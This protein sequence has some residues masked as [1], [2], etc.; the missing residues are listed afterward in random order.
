[1]NSVPRITVEAPVLS[2]GSGPSD[3]E[4][5]ARYVRALRR[6]K[7][8]HLTLLHLGVLEDFAR[9]ICEWTKGMTSVAAATG[10]T[11]AWLDGLPV[12]DAFSGTADRL[13]PLGGGR[14]SGL[15]VGV[16]EQ[17]HEYQV[18]LVQAL[19]E[20]LDGLLVDNVDD[21]I[22]SSRALGYRSPH[23]T[24]HVAVGS[25]TAYGSG[26]WDIERL[27]IQFGPSR[28]RNRQSLL[29]GMPPGTPES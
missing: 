15:E 28:I 21:F 26:S 27:P 1:M 13:I 18:R 5:L 6:Q 12:L 3:Y 4:G 10:A 9:D 16:P 14:V 29:P 23:W 25:P 2:V 19:H 7:G 11:V 20:L 22:L 8:L 17:V 24:P